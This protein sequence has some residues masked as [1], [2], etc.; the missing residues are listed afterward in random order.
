MFAV[1]TLRSRLEG[2]FSMCENNSGWISALIDWLE[3]VVF[4]FMMVWSIRGWC[5]SNFFFFYRGCE[6]L[7]NWTGLNN[8]FD[9]L[10]L[11]IFSFLNQ[12]NLVHL[13][14]L[15]DSFTLV[16]VR[17]KSCFAL[18]QLLMLSLLYFIGNIDELHSVLMSTMLSKASCMTLQS[19]LA[20]CVLCS[21]SLWFL[22]CAVENTFVMLIIEW[23]QY[24]YHKALFMDIQRK[25]VVLSVFAFY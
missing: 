16:W 9:F 3:H 10:F 20:F 21:F 5:D 1:V 7:L 24:Q 11:L 4:W 14:T 17:G 18:Q 25:F 2:V 13:L 23:N 8:L 19:T 6:L 12:T 15:K 22:C